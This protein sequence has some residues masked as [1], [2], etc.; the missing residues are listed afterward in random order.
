MADIFQ[1]QIDRLDEKIWRLD[2]A[3]RAGPGGEPEDDLRGREPEV[4]LGNAR[5][6]EIGR[7][8]VENRPLSGKPLITPSPYDG[9][10]G[11]LSSSIRT[12]CRIK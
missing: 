11:R 10:T 3:A 9:K 6:P 5:E 7:R 2:N 8:N 1:E 12:D 4:P